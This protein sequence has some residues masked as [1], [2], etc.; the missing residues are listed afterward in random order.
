[1][2]TCNDALLS[3]LVESISKHCVIKL[4]NSVLILSMLESGRF[5]GNNV[6]DEVKMSLQFSSRQIASFVSAEIISWPTGV[7][8]S[9]LSISACIAQLGVVSRSRCRS[10]PTSV[11]R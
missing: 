8:H 3:E 11:W 10:R 7:R 1:M 5:A 9:S 4:A 6:S 2:D